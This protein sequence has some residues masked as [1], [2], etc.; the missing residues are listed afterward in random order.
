MHPLLE[1]TASLLD[2]DRLLIAACDA[3]IETAGQSWA[4]A[5]NPVRRKPGDPLQLLL[6]GYAGARNTG[7]DVRVE[8]MIRQFRR[9]LGD[10]RASLTIMTN[11]PLLTRG[12]FRA[13]RQIHMPTVFPNFLR[14]E[15]PQHHGVVACEGS[16]FKSRFSNALS[17]MMTMALGIANAEGKLSVGY[18]AEAGEMT[19][20]LRRFVQRRCRHS[21]VICRNEPSRRVLEQLGIRT[22]GGTDTAWTFEPSP[23]GTAKQILAALGW[24]EKLPVLAVCPINPFW[25][26][27]KPNLVKALAHFSAGEFG[28]DHYRSIYFHEQTRRS[29]NAYRKYLEG[30]AGAINRFASEHGV[31]TVLVGMEALDRR[32]CEDLASLLHR[33]APLVISDQYDMFDMV[34]VLH[35]CS[36]VL[37]SRFHAIVTSMSNLV[38]SAGVTMDERIRNL[39]TDRRQPELFCEADDPDLEEKSLAMLRALWNEPDR[40]RHFIARALPANLRLM[41]QMGR[42]FAG[43]LRQVD[44][45][46]EPAVTSGPDEAW[47]PGLSPRFQNI[48]EAA[49]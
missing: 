26:P 45:D 4:R 40:A 12:Y 36:M 14:Q 13:V 5:E 18:G 15:C 7:A 28:E 43:E 29:R 2:A 9:I 32:A 25:W 10:D 49:A 41:A 24:D 35:Q 20:E 31:F 34:A 1:K 33:P 22:R 11:E 21:L 38:P 30:L 47:L 8:E 37:S 23:P 39:M 16:M 44:P 27:V 46:F 3:M 19:P 48:L 6:A 42:D 17:I